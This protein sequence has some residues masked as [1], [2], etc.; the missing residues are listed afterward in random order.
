M[1]H[2]LIYIVP[3]SIEEDTNLEKFGEPRL[4]GLGR[5]KRTKWTPEMGKRV[6]LMDENMISY[7][8]MHHGLAV[9]GNVVI[10]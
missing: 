4:Q 10:K 6:C 1:H 7:K 2:Y 5:G 3:K 8:D 9:R